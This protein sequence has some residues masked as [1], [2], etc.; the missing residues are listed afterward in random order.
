MNFLFPPLESDARERL[1]ALP[2]AINK[3]FP[4]KRRFSA[5]LPGNIARLSTLMTKERSELNKA[6][7]SEPAL[8]NAYL[9]YFLPWNVFRLARL[10]PSLFSGAGICKADGG[11]AGD[12]DGKADIVDFGSGPLTLPIA[13]WIALPELRKAPLRFCCVDRSGA[14]LDAG[15]KL[16]SAFAGERCPW[17]IKTI[18]GVIGERFT[19]KDAALVASV[20]VCNELFQKLPQA[21]TELL[22]VSAV[23]FARFIANFAGVSGRILLVEPG[24]PRPSQFLSMAR[25]TF[26]ENGFAPLSPC[27]SPAPAQCTMRGGRRGEKWCHFNLDTDEAPPEL[28]R[29]SARAFLQKEKVTLSFLLVSRE[30]AVPKKIGGLPGVRVISDMFPLPEGKA[31]RYA[32]TEKGLALIRGDKSLIEKY[33]QGSFFH[34]EL[35]GKTVIDRKSGAFILS[36]APPPYFEGDFLVK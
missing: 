15:K 2:S 28:Q 5:E 24:T 14:A 31:G 13:M 33:S 16:F 26:I 32:C 36:P 7:I 35:P 11:T 20:N 3:V 9:Y 18:R 21:D 25:D 12:T 27:P 22:R 17:R 19:F 34:T 29:L 8:L 10:L 1:L 4:L 23:K 6:Y 30:A